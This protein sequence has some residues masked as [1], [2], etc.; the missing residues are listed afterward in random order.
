MSFQKEAW[1]ERRVRPPAEFNLVPF[2]KGNGI[3]HINKLILTHDDIDHVGEVTTLAKHFKIDTIYI[4]WGAGKSTWLHTQL[5]KLEKAG[6]TICEVRQGDWIK[7]YFDFFVL[8][9]IT[10]GKGENEDSIG[11]SMTH[12]S[13]RFLFLGD[14]DQH[15]EDK[16]GNAYPDLKADVI[17]LGHHGSRTS[18]Y[19]QFIS[20]LEATY[21][22]L[23]CG[24]NN[25][26]GH[27]HEDV[28]ATLKQNKVTP[29]RTDRQGAITFKWHPFWYPNGKIH[30]M[31]D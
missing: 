7:G 9:P 20:Q 8:S 14:L 24:V 1:Q 31:I 17:K 30:T 27:P 3:R 4:G 19:P 26:F 21:G 28:L 25:L 22:V 5:Q 13:C 16:I 2:L 29:L 15:A 18:S 10:Q 11:L 12:Q 6:T 23:S